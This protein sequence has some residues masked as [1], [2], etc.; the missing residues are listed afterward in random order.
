MCVESHLVCWNKI[1]CKTQ[2]QYEGREQVHKTEIKSTVIGSIHR[3]N[4]EEH[5][6]GEYTEL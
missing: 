1:I 6:C 3:T 4:S 5:D 2:F